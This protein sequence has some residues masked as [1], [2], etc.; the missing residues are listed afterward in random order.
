MLDLLA[1]LLLALLLSA[2]PA[3]LWR[4]RRGPARSAARAAGRVALCVALSLPL[5]LAVAWKVSKA[6]RFQAFGRIVP[7]VET[8]D[9]L[10]ALTFDDGPNPAPTDTVLA[11]LAARGARATFFL[12]GE[13]MR[14]NPE[15]ARRIVAAGHEV[16][17]HS[18]HHP[19]MAMI[20]TRRVREEIERTDA[21]IR[22]AGYAGPIHF[23]P[24][25]GTK[26]LALPW[27]LRR[28]DRTAVTWDVEPDSYDELV[29]DPD[30]IARH[31]TERARPGSIVIL[32]VMTRHYAASRA[33]V[34]A[35]VQ[36]LQARGYRLVT[37]SE[38]VAAG[39]R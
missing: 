36:G 35:L 30:A 5:A 33:A 8:A 38:L 19:R 13:A 9:S 25:Y 34:P 27:V 37:V 10:V 16:G 29:R 6:R 18:F 3:V 22:R 26:L 39:E 11:M 4:R 2:P 31:V 21:E 14:R 23:R 1:V 20:S 32:H 17:N 12:T 15:A 28:M 7:R 24:P